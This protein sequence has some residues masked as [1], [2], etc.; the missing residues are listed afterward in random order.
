MLPCVEQCLPNYYIPQGGSSTIAFYNHKWHLCQGR[1]DG[2]YASTLLAVCSNGKACRHPEQA[3][4]RQP[5][6]LHPFEAV[7]FGKRGALNSDRAIRQSLENQK[8]GIAADERNLSAVP[9]TGLRAG[10]AT[11]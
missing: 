11:L 2:P 8:N 3:M 10:S 9:R 5:K 4:G 1:G 7:F 6:R